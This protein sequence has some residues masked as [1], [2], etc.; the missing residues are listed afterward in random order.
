M[1][2]RV[3][4]IPKINKQS[5]LRA[6]VAEKQPCQESSSFLFNCCAGWGYIVAFTKVIK[7]PKHELMADPDINTNTKII[8]F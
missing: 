1:V 7:F 8:L 2:W 4:K 6:Q 3:K 5:P